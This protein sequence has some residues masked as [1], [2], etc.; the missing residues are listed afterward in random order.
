MSRKIVFVTG[1]VGKLAEVQ[2]ILGD[3]IDME[4]QSVDLVEIQGSIEEVTR[5]KCRRAAETV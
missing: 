1:N 4:N 5:D 3:T 2:A